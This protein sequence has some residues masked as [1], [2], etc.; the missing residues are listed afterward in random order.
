MHGLVRTNGGEELAAVLEKLRSDRYDGPD[1]HAFRGALLSAAQQEI[2]A[3]G[4]LGLRQR[5]VARKVPH[6]W[7]AAEAV[8]P[9]EL[10]D[11]AVHACESQIACFRNDLLAGPPKAYSA[12]GGSSPVTY[13]V[14]RIALNLAN[15]VK[16]FRN[17]RRQADRERCAEQMDDRPSETGGVDD[18]DRVELRCDLAELLSKAGEQT[19]VAFRLKAAGFTD[20]E[21]ASRLG[22]TVDQVRTERYAFRRRIRRERGIE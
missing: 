21:I 17:A 13:L 15:L 1:W 6:N 11:F 9:H 22:I 12:C 5:K 3:M 16:S 19:A 18:Y 8:A 10:E 20:E 14:N 4:M 7:R 2:I